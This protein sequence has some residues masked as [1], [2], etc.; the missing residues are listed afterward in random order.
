MAHAGRKLFERV[1]LALLDKLIETR[2]L[3]QF[4]RVVEMPLMLAL[5]IDWY[6]IRVVKFGGGLG[7]FLEAGN[8]GGKLP[9]RGG[10]HLERDQPI[11][12]DLP[13]TIDDAHAAATQFAE[14]LK[15]TQSAAG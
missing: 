11:Q 8:G 12:R 5:G 14:D 6:D 7:L 15:V 10:E 13:G 2:T 3:D 9:N 1:P 4:H